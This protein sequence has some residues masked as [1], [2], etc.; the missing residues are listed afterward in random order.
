MVLSAW[1]GPAPPGGVQSPWARCGSE[2][3]PAQGGRPGQAAGP[4]HPRPCR[5]RCRRR[6][7]QPGADEPESDAR[8]MPPQGS[9]KRDKS[10]GPRAD[11]GLRL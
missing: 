6:R 4:D 11:S 8:H 9:W 3:E 7:L 1:A 10:P 2:A 5:Q